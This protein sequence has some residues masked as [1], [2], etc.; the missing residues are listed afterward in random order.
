MGVQPYP[1]IEYYKILVQRLLSDV[2]GSMHKESAQIHGITSL[3]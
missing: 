2:G 3:F 1:R